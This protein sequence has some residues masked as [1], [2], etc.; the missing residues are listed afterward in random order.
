MLSCSFMPDSF[1]T[2]QTGAHQAPLSMEF[3][4]QEHWSR[5]PFLSPRDIPGPD[6]EPVSP[7]LQAS[8]LPF[9]LELDH[10]RVAEF[11]AKGRGRRMEITLKGSRG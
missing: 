6:I 10:F 7:A 4:G 9:E 5:Q 2:P 8:S 11:Q 3:S 1:A